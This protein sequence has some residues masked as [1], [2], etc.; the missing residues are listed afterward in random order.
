MDTL[1]HVK[2]IGCEKNRKA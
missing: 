1:S 2:G